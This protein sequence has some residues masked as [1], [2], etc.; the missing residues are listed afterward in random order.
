MQIRNKSYHRAGQHRR[1]SK[2]VASRK[3]TTRRGGWTCFDLMHAVIAALVS[4]I[5]GFRVGAHAGG[6]KGIV[7]GATAGAI[8]S[9]MSHL[10]HAWWSRATRQHLC[11]LELLY[12]DVYRV[13]SVPQ[14]PVCVKADKVEI[15]Q[16]D[17][18]W[19]AEPIFK[20]SR[21]YLQ[22][23]TVGWCVAWYAGFEPDQIERIC[24]KP[25]L[26]YDLPYGWDG[27][28]ATPPPCPYPVLHSPVNDLGSPQMVYFPFVQGIRVKPSRIAEGMGRLFTR[29]RGWFVE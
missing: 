29:I 2:L 9:F 22:G 1:S 21:I 13:L 28:G 19:Q 4:G 23:L 24:R 25:H 7:A 14:E 6:A 11:K 3:R 5:I 20:D 15:E 17:Y 26:Q 27:P 8:S 16:G 10:A 12:P 18:G